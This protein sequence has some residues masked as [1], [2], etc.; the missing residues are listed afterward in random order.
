[1]VSLGSG[2]GLIAE[3]AAEHGLVH[4]TGELFLDTGEDEVAA[5]GMRDVA[6]G[7]AH[8]LLLH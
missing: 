8:L 6:E 4:D 3:V 1:M 5:V 2:G 7:E